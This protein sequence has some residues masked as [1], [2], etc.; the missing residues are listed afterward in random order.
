M[1]K[2][3]KCTMRD[4]AR[5][6]GVSTT[7][8]SAV[9]NETVTV[10]PQRKKK[11]LDAMAALDYHPDSVARS[12]KTGKTN[13]IG[14]VVP[15][16]T[17]VFYP[18]VVR[19]VEEAAGLAGYSVVLCDSGEDPKLEDRHLATLF[20]RRVEGVLL[21][22]CAGSTAYDTMVRRRFPM[23]FI[24][25]LPPAAA[26]GTVSTDNVQAGY[27]AAKHLIDL[28]HIR[29]AM[30]AGHLELSSHHDRLEGFRKAMQECHLPIRDE[31]LK[32]AVEGKGFDGHVQVE[33]GLD[34]GRQL[35]GLSTLPTAI[36]ANNNKLL[37]GVVQALE[38]GR[39]QVPGQL[40]VVGFD[41]YIWNRYFNP[42]LTAIAQPTHEMGKRAFE[43]LLTIV[44]RRP[45]EELAERN[46]RLAAELRVRNSTGAPP[47]ESKK[48]GNS[49]AEAI[50]SR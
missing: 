22:C 24:D 4:V 27:I 31:F 7:T 48:L 32:A 23:V 39:I 18:E 43:L 6:A 37:L 36:I 8:V 45:G 10:S 46:V 34:A 3:A 30:V 44:N 13:V 40:S 2:R 29:I 1:P 28:G 20:S 47:P 21:A 26:E 33:N 25:R 17:N 41:D 16:I 9:I 14:V 49:S 11:V 19:G 5:L 35:L 12:L 15:D 38:E 42:S 50:A